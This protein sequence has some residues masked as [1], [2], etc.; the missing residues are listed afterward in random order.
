MAP[1][2]AAA[3]FAPPPPPA[4]LHPDCAACGLARRS[5]ECP[6]RLPSLSARSQ[7]LLAATGMRTRAKSLW[8]ALCMHMCPDVLLNTVI[9]RALTNDF[10]VPGFVPRLPRSHVRSAF[11]IR[12]V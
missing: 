1:T 10:F 8:E 9:F 12:I 11:A 5:I 7:V 3:V 6:H 2:L 4:P